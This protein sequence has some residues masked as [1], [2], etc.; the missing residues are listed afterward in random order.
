M[1]L[2]PPGPETLISADPE[3]PPTAIAIVPGEAF[4]EVKDPSGKAIWHASTPE[5]KVLLAPGRYTVRM[6]VRD[7]ATEAALEVKSGDR[8]QIDLGAK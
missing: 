5:P 7:Q 3:P 8:R 1:R 6:E 2:S 4:W